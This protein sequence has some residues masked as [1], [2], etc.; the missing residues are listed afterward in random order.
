MAVWGVVGLGVVAVGVLIFVLLTRPDDESTADKSPDKGD[1]TKQ[2]Q[3]NAAKSDKPKPAASD[4]APPPTKSAKGDPDN[5]DGANN[6]PADKPND[7]PAPTPSDK[8]PETPTEQPT[9]PVAPP[10]VAV[11]QF[12]GIEEVPTGD[13]PAALDL[14]IAD[15][16]AMLAAGKFDE[17]FATHVDPRDRGATPP[18]VGRRRRDDSP[19]DVLAQGTDK[20]AAILSG[21]GDRQPHLFEDGKIAVF[22]LSASTRPTFVE[23]DG[24]WYLSR[25][26]AT[27]MDRRFKAL[28]DQEEIIYLLEI[29]SGQRAVAPADAG[30]EG[31]EQGIVEQLTQMGAIVALTHPDEEYRRSAVMITS[32]FK[33]GDDGLA[34][35]GQLSDRSQMVA[36]VIDGMTGSNITEEI[37]LMEL[38]GLEYLEYLRFVNTPV[39]RHPVT[40]HFADMSRL[41]TLIFDGG[42]QV[43]D[44]QINDH[45]RNAADLRRLSIK[46]DRISDSTLEYIKSRF[47]GLVSLDL[48]VPPGAVTPAAIAD[49]RKAIPGLWV[50]MR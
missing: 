36:L 46:G 31:T 13:R 8:P 34:L 33:G 25:G 50:D 27:S 21:I 47:A 17:F 29:T 2:A 18:A 19:Y 16:V 42:D 28:T 23:H 5:P 41:K 26:V 38:D 32:K 24:T 37:G 49:L 43:S 20:I 3:A 1:A 30:R 15:S 7:Q 40:V 39:T 10:A 48:D 14:L 45:L 35:L 12:R 22:E 6:K 44:V 11:K 9:P 4:D